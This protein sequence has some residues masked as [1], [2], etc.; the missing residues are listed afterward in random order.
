MLPLAQRRV[1]VTRARGQ[2]SA[3]AL[4]LEAQGATPIL[5]PAIELAPPASWC[6]LDATMIALRS[7]DWLLFTSANAVEAFMQRA[8]TLHLS[9]HP[10]RIAVIGPATAK[11]VQDSGLAAAIDL[12]PESYVAEA[13]AAAL[14]PHCPGAS[15]LLVRAAVARDVLPLALTQAGANLTIVDAYRNVIPQES[16]AAL[17]TLFSAESAAPLDAITFTS[18]STARNVAVLL[19]AAGL[20]VPASVALASIG[21]I[22]SAAMRSLGLKPTVEARES[23]I[24]A[25][26]DAMAVHFSQGG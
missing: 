1:L 6:P 2:A 15:L 26:V 13:F 7:F 10:Q 18:A 12:M 22:T 14:V 24:A 4:L 21:P 11:A 9:P 23:T 3:L 19:E 8:R 5:L 16:I 25:L 17:P 20:V